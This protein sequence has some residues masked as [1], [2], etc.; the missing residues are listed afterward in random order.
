MDYVCTSLIISLVHT[1]VQV[2]LAN[3]NTRDSIS[4]I[5]SVFQIFISVKMKRVGIFKVF[6]LWTNKVPSWLTSLSQRATT[7]IIITILRICD[8]NTSVFPKDIK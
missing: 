5:Q 2:R 3:K 4:I 6:V 1:Y 7:Q 8:G